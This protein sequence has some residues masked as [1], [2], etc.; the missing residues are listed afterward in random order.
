MKSQVAAQAA[1]EMNPEMHIQ[2]WLTRVAPETENVYNHV[3]WD[4]LTGTL[5]LACSMYHYLGGVTIL[6]RQLLVVAPYDSLSRSD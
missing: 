3:F 6:S 5:T 4:S 1:K 2:A